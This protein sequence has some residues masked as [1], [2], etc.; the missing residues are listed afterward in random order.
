MIAIK[1]YFSSRKRRNSADYDSPSGLTCT[2][3]HGNS[4][5]TN[6]VSGTKRRPQRDE[7]LLPKL[8]LLR[9]S[10]GYI[11]NEDNDA[12]STASSSRYDNHRYRRSISLGQILQT[13]EESPYANDY[14]RPGGRTSY[15]G[16]TEPSPADE[17]GGAG[18]EL[19]EFEKENL[20][21]LKDLDNSYH[22]PLTQSLSNTS[23]GSTY[24]EDS[25]TGDSTPRGGSPYPGRREYPRTAYSPS[26]TSPSK[27]IRSIS[28]EEPEDDLSEG[29]TSRDER[30]RKEV[31][32]RKTSLPILTS[33]AGGSTS[34]SSAPSSLSSLQ[35]AP[36]W[37][38][39]KPIRDPPPRKYSDNSIS[40]SPSFI[41]AKMVFSH[42]SLSSPGENNSKIPTAASPVAGS[43]F[44]QDSPWRK[45][46][47]NANAMTPET[48]DAM[49]GMES[50]ENETAFATIIQDAVNIAVIIASIAE[51]WSYYKGNSLGLYF[52]EKLRRPV[53]E[54]V[55]SGC[56]L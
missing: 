40:P 19:S 29:E 10:R 26:K 52:P 38:N 35:G 5:T 56:L 43:R 27:I 6:S 36:A 42:R 2:C 23:L 4:S 7:L 12:S 53:A 51:E 49:Q 14:S 45:S 3:P 18:R 33:R 34:D 11:R 54:T 55:V 41:Q 1:K 48:I 30:R 46:K 28:R 47:N 8:S 9:D 44:L 31:M 20:L 24:S 16:S 50:L 13:S 25:L 17:G 21:F 37:W 32:G 39:S 15:P 22:R